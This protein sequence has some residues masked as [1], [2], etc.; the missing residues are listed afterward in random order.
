MSDEKI[1]CGNAKEYNGKHGKFMKILFH[2][3]DLDKLQENM[4]NNFVSVMVS[5]RREPSAK[6]YTHLVKID[7]YEPPV[8][9]ENPL[10]G[11]MDQ[12]S[13]DTPHGSV[14][15]GYTKVEPIQIVGEDEDDLPF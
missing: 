8:N 10:S 13:S 2:Q 14:N 3:N 7:F 4:N 9:A 5:E 12:Q 1:Y 6:G 15:A 11:S